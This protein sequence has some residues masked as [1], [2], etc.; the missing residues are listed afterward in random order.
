MP[1]VIGA[2]VV[3]FLFVVAYSVSDKTEQKSSYEEN[4]DRK[5]NASM[6]QRLMDAYMKYGCSADEAFRR[7]Y[8]D[9]AYIGY[10]PCVP[11][12][13]YTADSSDLKV[14]STRDIEKYDSRLVHD[15]RVFYTK[16]W[17]LEHP[18]ENAKKHWAEIE[19]QVYHNFP[20]DSATASLDYRRRNNI[21]K[22]EPIGSF[23]IFPGLGTC[24]VLEHNWEGDGTFGGTYT[25]KSLRTGRIVKWVRIGDR[26]IQIREKRR[27]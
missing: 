21:S 5:T 13:A 22:A 2:L 10:E 25:L 8:E 14:G 17:E 1:L 27:Y 9:M 15:R 23:I 7:T 20:E 6:E 18:G 16:Q 12:D 11:R 19:E 3:V 24:E 26:R 4:R